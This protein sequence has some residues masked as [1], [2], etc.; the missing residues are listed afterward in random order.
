MKNFATD[1]VAALRSGYALPAQRDEIGLLQPVENP[2]I[3]GES[4]SKR[5]RPPLSANQIA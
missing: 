5:S 4:L 2:L 3:Q 1:F